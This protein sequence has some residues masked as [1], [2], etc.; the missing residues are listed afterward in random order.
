MQVTRNLEKGNYKILEERSDWNCTF[1]KFVVS[2]LMSLICRSVEELENIDSTPFRY[3]FCHSF[4][5]FTV[6]LPLFSGLQQTLWFQ[7][8]RGHN[9][10]VPTVCSINSSGFLLWV[11]PIFQFQVRFESPFSCLGHSLLK[12]HNLK[13]KNKE[14]CKQ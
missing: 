12:F 7:F 4:T 6:L 9:G 2:C 1:G 3:K 10:V 11:Y 5:M 14:R 8:G 13:L